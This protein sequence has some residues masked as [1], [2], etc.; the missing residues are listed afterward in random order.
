MAASFSGLG[1]AFARPAGRITLPPV[2]YLNLNLS[3]IYCLYLSLHCSY[4]GEA[5]LNLFRLPRHDDLA[6]R[7]R[8]AA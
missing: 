7:L 1:R 3:L 6:D 8:H 2:L 5:N 4:R